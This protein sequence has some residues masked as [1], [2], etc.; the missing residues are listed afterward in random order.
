MAAL[1]PVLPAQDIDTVLFDSAER[2]PA[3][4]LDQIDRPDERRALVE[5]AALADPA[6]RLRAAEQFLARYPDSWLLVLAS[7]AAAKAAIALRDVPAAERHAAFALRLMPENPLLLAPLASLRREAGRLEEAR[8]NARLVIEYLDRFAAP[9]TIPAA[10]WGPLEQRVRFVARDILG[11]PAEQASSAMLRV[12]ARYAGSEACR[13]CHAGEHANWRHTG[14]ANML[15][16]YAA[17]IVFAKPGVFENSLRMLVDRGRHHVEVRD[18]AGRWQRFRVDY[19]IGSKWQQAY[20]TRAADGGIHVF[21]AQYNRLLGRWVNYWK[22]ID[23]PDAARGTIARFPSLSPETN[24]QR[25][26]APCHTSRL[27]A[28]EPHAVF[29]EP[30]VHCESC[31]GPS[32]PHVAAARAGERVARRAQ[33]PPVSFRGLDAR[34][35]VEIC[36]QCHMQSGLLRR[37]PAGEL[38]HSD[39]AIQF[40]NRKKSRP[41]AEFSRKAFYRDGRFRETT[42]IG[43]AFL[44]T[45]CHREGQAHCGHCHNPHPAD[46][47]RNPVSLKFAPDADGMCTQCHGA[48]RPHARHAASEAGARCVNCHMPRIMNSLLFQARTHEIGIPDAAMNARFG[49]RESPLACRLCHDDERYRSGIS[50]TAV[51]GR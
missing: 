3:T 44:R 41:L 11:G 2:R 4:L 39:D 34:R 38:N 42:F 31:H 36:S 49:Q 16:P 13:G 24:Y 48:T 22:H 19:V 37:G 8:A 43:E 12:P 29:A 18:A 30:G 35:Y 51:E 26:C 28:A 7:E 40:V 5:L 9:V 46:A 14:M 50:G 10:E 25:N 47:A 23:P 15:R 20:A 32:A 17:G 33:D 21:P 45:R 1:A 27:R 6:E